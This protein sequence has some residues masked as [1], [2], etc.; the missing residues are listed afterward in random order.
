MQINSGLYVL[1]PTQ[2]QTKQQNN[3][4]IKRKLNLIC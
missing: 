1:N 3:V 4:E 2:I